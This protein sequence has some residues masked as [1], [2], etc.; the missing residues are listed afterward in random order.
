MLAMTGEQKI[1]LCT[2]SEIKKKRKKKQQRKQ[3][4]IRKCAGYKEAK[5]AII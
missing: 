3:Y 1:R 5:V 2:K 4:T